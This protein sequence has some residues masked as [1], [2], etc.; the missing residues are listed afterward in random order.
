MSTAPESTYVRADGSPARILV[1][2]DE[3]VLAELLG[4]ALRHRGWETRTAANGWEALD[5]APDFDPDVVVLD[6]QM[7][8]LDGLETLERLRKKQPH[9]PVLFLTARDAVADRVT[10][11]RAGADDY[12]TKPFDLDEVT[13][14]IDALLRRAGMASQ[15]VR[16]VLVV[17]DLVLDEDSHD[18]TRA[19]VP[20]SL[21]NTEFEVL[22]YLMENPNVVLSKSQIL[23]RVWS[24][25]FGGQANVV[26][27]YISYLRKKIEVDQEP[28]IHTVR[29]AGYII[30]PAAGA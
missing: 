15:T 2:D 18:V 20:I 13:A 24:Y 22:R 3:A 21:T 6:I 8:G 29:G 4:A 7:P 26:E 11:L 1:V 30:R 25:D 10:G 16:H 12:V 28:M 27:L 5:I 9:L 17:G 19:G 14:R 23:D